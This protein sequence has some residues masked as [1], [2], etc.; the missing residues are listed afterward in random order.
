MFYS[1]KNKYISKKKEFLKLLY[2]AL[3]YNLSKIN[4]LY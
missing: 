1:F 4:Y 2:I 3:K